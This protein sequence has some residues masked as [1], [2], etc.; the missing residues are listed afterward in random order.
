MSALPFLTFGFCFPPN[1][2]CPRC[3]SKDIHHLYESIKRRSPRSPPASRKILPACVCGRY[4]QEEPRSRLMSP[5]R[6]YVSRNI[7]LIRTW[8]MFHPS[9]GHRQRSI[10]LCRRHSFSQPDCPPAPHA[11][12]GYLLAR[13]HDCFGWVPISFSVAPFMGR[14]NYIPPKPNI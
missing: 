12:N 13:C 10:V 2:S 9:P 6:E 11:F 5:N 8:S 7:K 4:A 1:S 14:L 3:F